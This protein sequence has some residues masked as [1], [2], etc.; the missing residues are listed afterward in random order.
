MPKTMPA[1]LRPCKNDNFDQKAFRGA[2]LKWYDRHAR[3]LPWRYTPGNKANPYHV[4]LS[5]VMLQQTTVQAVIPYF[6]KF[7]DKWSTVQK[8]AAAKDEDVMHAWA[9]LGYYARARNLLKCA[10]AVSTE[11]LGIF[12]ESI[13]SLKTLPGIGDYT[14]AAIASIAFDIP[15]T[16]IDGNVDRVVSRYFAIQ[17]PLPDS[18]P[19][20]REQAKRLFE[21]TVKRP[22]DFAQAMMDLGAT[23]CT[24]KSPKC[25]VCPIAEHCQARLRGIATELPHRREKAVQPK[26][27]GYV[28]W[29]TNSK[30]EVLF[31]TRP[32]T[33]LL[34]GMTGLPTSDWV[35]PGA[36]N[37]ISAMKIEDTAVMN[38]NLKIRHT[39]TH[40]DLELTGVK[41]PAPRGFRLSPNQFWV[42]PADI[43]AL[44]FPTV[45]RKFVRLVLD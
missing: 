5:E 38:K 23:I 13:D 7:V 9:G 19:E 10:R 21:G 26:R 14:A 25:G 32:P 41:L 28:Y 42:A 39:F 6:G 16:V 12:P 40:F 37:H 27:V 2:L 30:G 33:G 22:G 36:I 29:V 3:V 44:G 1:P 11:H 43:P 20:I 8:L 34:G 45:F 17:D 18:K 15:A 35:A 31:E 4:W 24:P